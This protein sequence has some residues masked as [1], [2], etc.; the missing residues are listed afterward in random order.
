[1]M[2]N[3]PCLDSDN[4]RTIVKD[5]HLSQHF[6]LDVVVISVDKDLPSFI[7]PVASPIMICIV[8]FS[9]YCKYITSSELLLSFYN[10]M[11]SSMQLGQKQR[12]HIIIKPSWLN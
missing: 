9:Q 6:V 3:P 8:Q 2:S 4:E 11:Y 7:G 5:H 1:M 10:N 12:K